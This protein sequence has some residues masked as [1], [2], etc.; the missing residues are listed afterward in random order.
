LVAE[1]SYAN[2]QIR[3]HWRSER[4]IHVARCLRALPSV[5]DLRSRPWIDVDGASAEKIARTVEL[6]PT[7]ALAY[8]R[9]DGEPGDQP[10]AETTVAVPSTGPL[11]VRGDLRVVR[12][13]GE[14]IASEPRLALCR[15]GQSANQPFCD[16]SHRRT[17]FRSGKPQPFGDRGEGDASGATTITPTADGPLRFSGGIRVLDRRGEQI[18]SGDELSL[19]R[20]GQSGS[21]PL[22]DGS[23]KRCGFASTEP[24]VAAERAGAVS[25]ASIAENRDL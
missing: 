1:R 13:E 3:V 17:G 22:C 7:G 5:F 12:P 8:E 23:H 25:P 4:C 20:C 11:L 2:D 10:D 15:C 9:L 19:C 16:N 21:K 18:G 6:C 14:L 24:E